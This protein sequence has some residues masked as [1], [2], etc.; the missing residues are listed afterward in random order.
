MKL[1]DGERIVVDTPARQRWRLAVIGLILTGAS[2]AV[3]ATRLDGDLGLVAGIL[4]LVIFGPLTV[5][6][7]LRA[8]RRTPAL[9][10]DA[11]GF[12]GHATASAA[13][14]VAWQDVHSID[15]R[16]FMGRVFVAVTVR[17]PA[18]FRRR[19]PAWQRALRGINRHLVE[20]DVLIPE[21]VLPM[22][23]AELARTMRSLRH[24]SHG[25]PHDRG[26]P[27]PA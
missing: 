3:A 12:T 8:L 10:L 17:D 13:R 16:L 7:L 4:G 15:E 23:A 20:G 18:A 27:T 25:R 5:T 1:Q 11:G 21:T 9:V 22:S 19:L 24:D 2:A 26:Q 14:Y 6:L